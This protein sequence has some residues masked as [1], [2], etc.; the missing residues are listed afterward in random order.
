M[1]KTLTNIV[2][3]LI[4]NNELS[5]QRQTGY[6]LE[7][8]N[9]P[10]DWINGHALVDMTF[11]WH[12]YGLPIT[13]LNYFTVGALEDGVTSRYSETSDLYQAWLGG[14][15]FRSKKPLHWHNDGYLRLA[16]A[17]QKG[18]LRRFGAKS[19]EMN[20]GKLTDKEEISVAG[21]KAVLYSWRGITHSDVGVSTQGLLTTIMMDGMADM[22]NVM[23][24]GLKLEGK[25]FIPPTPD[26]VPFEELLI[27]GYMILVNIDSKTK[28]V[29]Y[30]CMVG[31]N[32]PDR[33]IMKD[34][35]TKNLQ[36]VEV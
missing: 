16:E 34:L 5:I 2:A 36:L 12:Q 26:R 22:M 21:K 32:K 33:K 20:F 10:S 17:D 4:L 6:K 29:L 3:R 35:I 8:N 18:W 24:P 25:N 15:I 13:G 1:L 31:D 27:S 28:A 19:P 30:V 23:T 9:L 7:F 11:T 14:Y